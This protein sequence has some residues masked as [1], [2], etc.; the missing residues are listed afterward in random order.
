ML[1][2]TW[3]PLGT[4]QCKATNSP[5]EGRVAGFA[6][7]GQRWLWAGSRFP[8]CMA[9]ERGI[10]TEKPRSGRWKRSAAESQF[11][12]A[13]REKTGFRSSGIHPVLP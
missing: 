6:D 4:V 1:E 9:K 8:A 3:W 7:V 13:G 11:G 12:G 5:K 10:T 2:I